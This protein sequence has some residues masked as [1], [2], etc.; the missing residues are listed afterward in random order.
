MPALLCGIIW[1]GVVILLFSLV[2]RQFRAHRATA[3][4]ASVER[5]RLP[6]V[7]IIVPVRNEIHNVARCLAG[8]TAQICLAPRS[9]ITVVDDGSDD[10]TATVVEHYICVGLRV[11]LAAAGPLPDGWV[12]KPYACWRGAL[13]AEGDWL[14]FIDADVRVAPELV[15]TA[16]SSAEAQGIDMLSLHPFQELGSFWERLVI[17]A[18]FLMIACAKG[19]QTT[20]D[21]SSCAAT[22]NGQFMLVRRRAYFGVGGHAA[23]AAEI[24]EDKALAIRVQQ[25]GFRFRVL[26][27]EHL[28]TTRMYRDFNSLWEGLSKNAIEILGNASVTLAAAVSGIVVGWTTLALPIALG[29][30]LLDR[31]SPA[32]C[33]GFALAL[34]GSALVIGIQIGTAHH[35]RISAAFGLL[36]V[37]G[38]VV[39]ALIACHSALLRYRGRVTWKG[40]KYDL[41]RKTSPGRS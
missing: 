9:S 19:F 40:R 24:C 14:C 16:I 10:G 35:F 37:C 18:G 4:D 22:A 25:A 21:P 12:G 38:Y 33:I 36:F 13:L 11:R 20:E 27:A 23:V 5:S 34:F 6:I 2:M 1:A 7:S 39:A 26:A 8:L 15:A 29:V 3:L 17:P 30:E 31:P 28:A 32:T 41:H